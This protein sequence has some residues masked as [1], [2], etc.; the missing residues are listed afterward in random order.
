MTAKWVHKIKWL[1]DGSI[2]KYK[3]PARKVAAR[4]HAAQPVSFC[5]LV[6]KAVNNDMPIK[7]LD[8]KSAFMNAGIDNDEG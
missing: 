6:Q 3:R 2:D 5:V 7:Q 4:F 8:V 1:A